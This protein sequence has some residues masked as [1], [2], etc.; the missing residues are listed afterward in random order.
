MSGGLLRV[1]KGGGWKRSSSRRMEYFGEQ[2]QMGSISVSTLIIQ[3]YRTWGRS[4]DRLFLRDCFWHK[5]EKSLQQADQ[6]IDSITIDYNQHHVQRK[7]PESANRIF[8]RE[9]CTKNG[10]LCS[11]VNSHLV[12]F[13][14]LD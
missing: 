12:L 4:C 6:Y 2:H 8:W 5:R 9:G 7:S 11:E 10:P 3:I 1:L 14:D 13:P